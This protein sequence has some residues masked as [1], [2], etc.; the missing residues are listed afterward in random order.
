[1]TT[2]YTK[3]VRLLVETAL[4]EDI[5]RGDLTSLACLE[6]NNVHAAITA[7]SEGIASGLR[8][9]LLT[10]DTVDSANIVRP[11]IDSGDR[12]KPGDVIFEIEGFNQTILTAERTA[13]NFMARLS[14]I[15]TLTNKFVEK[16]KHTNCSVLDTRKTTPGWR[17]LEKEAVKHGGGCNHRMGLF[18]MILIKDNHI[19]SS[20]SV[21]DA[22]KKAKA[23][24]ETADFRI[25]FDRKGDEIEIEVEVVNES[26]LIEAIE[27]GIKRLLLD[28]QSIESL[29]ALVKKARSIN[30]QIKLEASGNVNLDTIKDIAES[31]VDFVSVGSLTHSATASDFSLN[32]ID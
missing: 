14:G 11:L 18:D 30:P 6:P 7:K 8:P 21:S 9:A 19:A 10:F 27:S 17:Y 12:F 16:I 24:L 26:Q 29:T 1:M 2:E 22:V 25:Q 32:V 23:Y 31:G 15:A 3:S 4:K 5:G 13:L 20:G 28:N